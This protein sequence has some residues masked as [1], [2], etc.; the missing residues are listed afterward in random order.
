[1]ADKLTFH[2]QA[3]NGAQVTQAK[4]RARNTDPAT[5]S[6]ELVDL[7]QALSVQDLN[8]FM[9][10]IVYVG[11][12]PKLIMALLQAREAN[13]RTLLSDLTKFCVFYMQRGT[14]LQKAAT[15]MGD[16]GKATIQALITKYQ[17]RNH[18]GNAIR[19]EDI[20][21]ARIAS[22]CACQLVELA[23]GYNGAYKV[24]ANVGAPFIAQFPALPGAISRQVEGWSTLIRAH[25]VWLVQFDAVI[26]SKRRAG[27]TGPEEL[28]HYMMNALQSEWPGERIRFQTMA[29]SGL[30]QADGL[31]LWARD[32]PAY[33]TRLIQDCQAVLNNP[34]GATALAL[35]A[36][37]AIEPAA[38]AFA[39][40]DRHDELIARRNAL[41]AHFA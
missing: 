32:V 37:D 18:S 5:M 11:F 19:N 36:Y 9:D 41:V 17:I 1:M 20:T 2:T 26:N 34:T 25:I 10:A 14:N 40:E 24:V 35:A 27:R 7:V 16:Q 8:A 21:V 30:L 29:C 6:A 28:V 33:S 15:R 23:T 4:Q 39:Y 12:D 22:V 13:N 38:V 31:R 3:D